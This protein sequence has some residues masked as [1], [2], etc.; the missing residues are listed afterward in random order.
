MKTISWREQVRLHSGQVISVERSEQYRMVYNGGPGLSWLFTAE[1]FQAHLPAPIGEVAWTGALTPLA[2]DVSSR[3]VVYLVTV[4][5]TEAGEKE[6]GRM[7]ADKA[8]VAFKYLGNGQ[9]Q[10]IPIS[11]IPKEFHP[12]LFVNTDTLFFVQHSHIKTVSLALKAKL[13]SD[14]RIVKAFRGW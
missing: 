2:L 11:E 7:P 4:V 3:N 9:W 1:H 12:N 5:T 13:D 14:P 6:Y 8:H 10:E